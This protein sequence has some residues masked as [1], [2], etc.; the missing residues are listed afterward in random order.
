MNCCDYEVL[1]STY[2]DDE[3]SEGEKAYLKAHLRSCEKCRKFYE[4]TSSLQRGITR[5]LIDCPDTPD[6][7][8]AVMAQISP[9]PMMR[10]RLAWAAA[11]V[12]VLLVIG[13]YVQHSL[14]SSHIPIQS[15]KNKQM[16]EKTERQVIATPNKLEIKT[17]EAPVPVKIA[18]RKSAPKAV[19]KSDIRIAHVRPHKLQQK[20]QG[21][22]QH[23]QTPVQQADTNVAEVSIEYVDSA[24]AAE[25]T[26]EIAVMPDSIPTQQVVSQTEEVIWNGKRVKRI[27]NRVI[28]K[29]TE[30]DKGENNAAN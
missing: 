16:P 9:K 15:T 12:V 2:A 24:P 1:I 7:A 17:P 6:I 19:N 28:P 20:K 18:N 3:L 29:E 30:P 4:E 10:L 21:R 23:K 25:H 26:N 22:V 13:I 5:A 11:A 27:C 8:S 14:S